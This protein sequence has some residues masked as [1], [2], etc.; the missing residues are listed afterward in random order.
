MFDTSPDASVKV[1]KVGNLS[2]FFGGVLM[3]EVVL[4]RK[5]HFLGAL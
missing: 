3:E 1:Q 5:F 2:M 4:W